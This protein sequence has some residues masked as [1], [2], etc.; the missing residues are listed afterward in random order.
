MYVFVD[1]SSDN[2]TNF[3]VSE[4]DAAQVQIDSLKRIKLEN[5]KS[6]IF[7]FNPNYLTDFKAYQLGL[8]VE[9]IDRL[10]NYRKTGKFVNSTKEF[11]KITGVND[12][13]LS[14]ISPYFKFPEWINSKQKKGLT[15]KSNIDNFNK[16]STKDL[17]LATIN[18]LK[19]INGIGDK[20]AKRIITYR[21]L[22]KGYTYNEQLYEVYYLDKEVADKVLKQFTVSKKPIIQKINI[23]N[24]TFKDILHLPYIDYKL[25][26]KICN[27]RDEIGAYTSLE[28]LKKI[29][30]FPLEKFDR[31]ALYLATD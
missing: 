14:K 4:I 20:L 15:N 5:S 26:K 12:S 13:L 3:D 25:T 31:I 23:N 16:P 11:Q 9:E 8:S 22:L 1:F 28:D 6:K 30:S 24:A 10:F 19:S 2:N 17:N 27:Y 7:P 29:D 18:D 21:E